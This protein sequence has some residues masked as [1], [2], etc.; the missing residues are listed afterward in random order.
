[1]EG[2]LANTYKRLPLE[3]VRGRGALAYDA[4]GK[5]YIDLGSGIGVNLLGYC[6]EGW[7]RAVTDQLQCFQHCSNLYESAP[8][9][10]LAR[11]LCEKTGMSRVFFSNSGAEANEC[12]IKVARK[13]A[14]T[15]KGL[16]E[17]YIITLNRSFHGRTIAALSATGQEV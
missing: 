14:E 11:L 6:D 9:A 8:A 5:E 2:Y 4:Q 7:L 1:M 13:W 17:S 10:E 15:E 16:P 12:A 3:I